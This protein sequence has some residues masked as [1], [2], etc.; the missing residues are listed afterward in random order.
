MSVLGLS[1]FRVGAHPGPAV[2]DARLDQ[3]SMGA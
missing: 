1:A 3:T 2:L